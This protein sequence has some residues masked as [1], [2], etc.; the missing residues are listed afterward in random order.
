MGLIN[1]HTDGS[2][3][4]KVNP[5]VSGWAFCIEDWNED[6]AV[7]YWESGLIQNPKSRQIDGEVKA[8]LM[9]IE[10]A[11]K[12]NVSEINIY[13]DYIGI[14]KWADGEWKTRKE[15]SSNYFFKVQEAR[16]NGLT[17]NYFWERGHDG[18]YFNMV[19]DALATSSVDNNILFSNGNEAF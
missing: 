13:H 7:Y 1:I 3:K 2:Y 9:A 16:R 11:F 6:Q 15:V 18:N 10:W 8:V 4:Q 19:A 12:H 14:G 17:I 5:N